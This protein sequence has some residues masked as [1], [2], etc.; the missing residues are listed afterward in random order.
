MLVLWLNCQL[1]YLQVHQLFQNEN[2]EKKKG[3]QKIVVL[4][5]LHLNCPFIDTTRN[6]IIN[7]NNINVQGNLINIRIFHLLYNWLFIN[8]NKILILKIFLK[9]F[10][11]CVLIFSEIIRFSTYVKCLRYIMFYTFWWWYKF[12]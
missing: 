5:W 2:H 12:H 6:A 7:N 11:F 8:I 9:F 3:N 10:N 1:L 4:K